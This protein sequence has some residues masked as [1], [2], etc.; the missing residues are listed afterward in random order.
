LSKRDYYEILNISRDASKEDA[1]NAY[2]KLA[3]KYHP[4]RN[5]SPEAE[6]KFKEISEAY[7]VLSDDEKR[8]QYDL[9]GHAGIEGR[10]SWDEIFRPV[11]FDEIFRDLG[12]SGFNRIFDMFFGRSPYGDYVP[13][14]GADLRYDLEISLEEAASGLNTEIEVPRREVCRTCGG[15]GAKPGTNPR[16]CPKCHGTGQVQHVQTSGFARFVRIETCSLCGGRRTVVDNPCR[17]CRG[18][19]TVYLKR[20]IK[21]KVPSGIDSGFPLRLTGEGEAGARGAPPGDLYLYVSVKPHKIFER[22]GDNIL[23]QTPITF[24]QAALG[25]EIEVPTLESKAKMKIPAGTQT[26][27]LFRLKGKGMPK[28]RRSGRGDQYVRVVIH[29]PTELTQ[30]QRELLEQLSRENL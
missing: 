6:E 13:Q 22:D 16:S 4:D 18:T 11:N 9:F 15:S 21:I 14:S 19:G 17:D 27:S 8:K 26:G 23:C 5:K 3:M 28:L 10:Y 20:K 1:K 29:T 30:R 12:F 24:S 7:A 25:G 2:R